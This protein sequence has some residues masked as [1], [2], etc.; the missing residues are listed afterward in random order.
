MSDSKHSVRFPGESESYRA[1]P[2]ELLEAEIQLRR[3]IE[4]VAAKRRDLP[5][6]GKVPEGYVFDEAVSG[7]ADRKVRLSELFAPDKDTL[8]V[9]SFMYGPKMAQPCVSCTS[10]LD[11]L[12]GEAP[13]VM[14]RINLAVVAKSPISRIMEFTTARAWRNLRLLS[15]SGNTY[16]HDYHAES[17]DFTRYIDEC[18]EAPPPLLKIGPRSKRVMSG[19]RVWW[20]VGSTKTSWKSVKQMTRGGSP[21]K[22]CW[23]T[24]NLQRS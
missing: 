7:S 22:S 23:R 5:L 8:M 10:I 3:S 1:A 9:Y 11:A 19:S 14:Q 2:N 21:L 24:S 4:D 12:D 18:L 15:S 17:P 16:N 13:H 20:R 6:G